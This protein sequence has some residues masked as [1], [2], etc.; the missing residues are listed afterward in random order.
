M[1]DVN[2]KPKGDKVLVLPDPAKNESK[3]VE[4]QESEKLR[5]NTGTVVAVGEGLPEHEYGMN[6][7]VGE[8]VY[9][10]MH[11]SQYVNVEG[12]EYL[13]MRERDL[14]GNLI[15]EEAVAEEP[16]AEEVKEEATAE[17]EAEEKKEEQPKEEE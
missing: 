8:R 2:F 10:P 6:T 5:P 4:M 17:P 16:A 11:S 14:Q 1:S 13:I 7:T 15:R 9:F 3:I 12:V